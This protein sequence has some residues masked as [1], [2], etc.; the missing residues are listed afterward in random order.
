MEE[1]KSDNF[2][3]KKRIQTFKTAKGAL[4][5]LTDELVVD[6]VRAW[7]RWPGTGKAFYASLGIKKEQLG[8]IMRKG[9]RLFKEGKE[10]L[11]P[12]TPIEA[13]PPRSSGAP[14]VL[15]W[16]KGKSIRFYQV[17]QLVEFLKKA[18]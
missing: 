2:V 6:I 11:G 12:F 5:G 9:K 18:A 15:N 16:D 17:E 14:I 8:F 10:K 1:Q 13:K 3:L 4:I 7:E